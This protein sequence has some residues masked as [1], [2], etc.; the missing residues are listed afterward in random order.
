MAVFH[1]LDRACIA[2]PQRGVLR[3]ATETTYADR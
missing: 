1:S 2:M 3:V